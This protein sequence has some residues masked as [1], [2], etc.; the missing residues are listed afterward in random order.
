MPESFGQ[1]MAKKDYWP[2]NI[3][4]P[5]DRNM[6]DDHSRPAHWGN[7]ECIILTDEEALELMYKWDEEHG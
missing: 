6:L 4:E 7:N 5:Y 1:V 2:E 3:I